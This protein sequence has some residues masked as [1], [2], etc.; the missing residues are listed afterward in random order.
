MR[1]VKMSKSLTVAIMVFTFSLILAYQNCAPA[2]HG[3]GNNQSKAP[4]TELTATVV[5]YKVDGC[6]VL[7]CMQDNLL[8]QQKCVIPLKMDSRYIVEGNVVKVFGKEN[9]DT[10]TT[11]MAGNVFEVQNVQLVSGSMNAIPGSSPAASPSASP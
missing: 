3:D 9:F 6:S 2:P 8:N 5:K 4:P 7:L 11:C 10:V 1:G